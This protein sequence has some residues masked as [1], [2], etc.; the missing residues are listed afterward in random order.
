M[1]LAT[2]GIDS[3]FAEAI[4]QGG[5]AQDI[6]DRILAGARQGRRRRA[7]RRGP[8]PA[9]LMAAGRTLRVDAEFDVATAAREARELAEACGLTGVEAQ[10]VATA[11]SEVASNAVKYAGG[12]EVE[13]DPAERGGRRGLR[14]VVRDHGPGIADVPRRCA[15]GSRPAARSGSG[16]RARG[17]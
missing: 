11:V 15:T 16:C 12:G 5:T 1:V 2:D 3:G 13:L 8:L 10:H 9:G 17:G 4:T 14:V 6:A 7:R